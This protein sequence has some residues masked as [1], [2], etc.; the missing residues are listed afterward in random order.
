[1]VHNQCISH[2][3][4]VLES[5]SL[6]DFCTTH[7]YDPVKPVLLKI[8]IT[9]HKMVHNNK[10]VLHYSGHQNIAALHLQLGFFHVCLSIER[11]P[12]YYML[13]N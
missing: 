11:Y 4:A 2:I 13:Y 9:V 7:S 1:M 8:R 3:Q 5:S 6:F 10:Q 12:V